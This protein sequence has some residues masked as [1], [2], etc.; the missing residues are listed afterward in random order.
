M[1]VNDVRT[2]GLCGTSCLVAPDRLLRRRLLL[3]TTAHGYAATAKKLF[4]TTSAGTTDRHH[5]SPRRRS[6]PLPSARPLSRR[7]SFRDGT[8]PMLPR[9]R[10][11]YSE[12][13][14]IQPRVK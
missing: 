4:D 7:R 6:S 9:L 11:R 2:S 8:S 14:A 5:R 10:Q 13:S 3:H 1:A 12:T